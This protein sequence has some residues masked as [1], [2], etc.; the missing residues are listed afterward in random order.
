[1]IKAK[2]VTLSHQVWHQQFAWKIFMYQHSRHC[3]FILFILIFLEGVLPGDYL[4]KCL[5]YHLQLIFC[6]VI[7]SVLM[8][9]LQR[10]FILWIREREDQ[11]QVPLSGVPQL[12]DTD[13]IGDLG[14]TLLNTNIC[15]IP[16]CLA[17]RGCGGVCHSP[18]H[19]TAPVD[20]SPAAASYFF[21]QGMNVALGKCPDTNNKYK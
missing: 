1:M 9:L 7:I 19:C 10:T 12:W 15:S 17:L 3:L 6:L 4:C 20:L 8:P 21:I 5:W 18:R 2:E 16:A 14:I 11:G 13:V